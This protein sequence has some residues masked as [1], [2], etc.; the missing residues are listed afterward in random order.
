MRNV[1]IQ[2]CTTAL[3]TELSKKLA[4]LFVSK[5]YLKFLH[6]NLRYRVNFLRILSC[7][8]YNSF[9]VES[10]NSI[11]NLS[12]ITYE[13]KIVSELHCKPTFEFDPPRT[14]HVWGT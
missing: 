9:L 12:K 7:N 13:T 8:K 4:Q 14:Y 1:K 3:Y 5:S 2:K 6:L 11:K 10:M